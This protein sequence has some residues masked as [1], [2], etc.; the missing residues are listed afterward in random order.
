MHPTRYQISVLD[1]NMTLILGLFESA[2][3]MQQM[4]NEKEWWKHKRPSFIS[5]NAQRIKTG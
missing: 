1:A 5:C 2:F 4:E 3:A